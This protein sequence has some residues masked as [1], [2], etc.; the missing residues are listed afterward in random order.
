MIELPSLY[1]HQCDLRDRTRAALTFG[2]LFAGIGGFDLGFERAG[3]VCKWQVEIDP[4]CQ[5]VLAKHWPHVRRHDDVRTFPPTDAEDWRIDVICGGFP[6]QDIS[7]A[8]LRA[9]IEGK[10]SGL[11]TEFARVIRALRPR[12]VAVE[13]V[14]ALLGRGMERVLGDLATNGFD[15]EWEVL[16]ACAFGAPHSRE[17]VFLVAYAASQPQLHESKREGHER[18]GAVL[19]AGAMRPVR[20]SYGWPATPA[21]SL[22]RWTDGIPDRVER[23][24]VLGN[25]VVPQ[26]AQWIGERIVQAAKALTLPIGV[27]RHV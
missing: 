27:R 4:F 17:R 5:K 22:C 24:R 12:F 21:T 25:A 6:C 19:D 3:M 15:A 10:Q 18:L 9:G 11:W 20:H 23:S 16:P 13:N 7:D 8:G 2:S 1:P 14:A 26:V